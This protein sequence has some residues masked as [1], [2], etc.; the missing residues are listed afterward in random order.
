MQS[1]RIE[2]HAD[3]VFGIV[4][5]HVVLPDKESKTFLFT[6]MLKTKDVAAGRGWRLVL[7]CRAKNSRILK[8]F[9]SEPMNGT[10]DWK[11]VTLEGDLPKG[12]VKV[13]AGIMLQ[14]VG[15]GWVDDTYLSVD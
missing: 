4:K 13:D 6:A 9:Q 12:T 5:Q 15:I 8:Q 10:T 7:N 14:S 11:K 2:Q 1:Y 3:Q